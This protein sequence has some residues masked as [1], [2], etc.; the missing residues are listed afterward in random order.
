VTAKSDRAIRDLKLSALAGPAQVLVSAVAYALVYP[1]IVARS[2]L[3]VL[4]L[5]SFLASLMA[6]LGLADVGFSSLIVRKVGAN[7]TG[8]LSSVATEYVTARRF[9]VLAGAVAVVA[10]VAVLWGG[11]AELPGYASGA[12][13][14]LSI[15][16]LLVAT[17][18]QLVTQLVQAVLSGAH[19]TYATQVINGVTPPIRLAATLVGALAA[20]PIEGLAAGALLEAALRYALSRWWLARRVP[21]WRTSDVRLGPRGTW[22][23]LCEMIRQGW[24]LYAISLGFLLRE[25]VFRTVITMSLGLAATGVYEIAARIPDALRTIINAGSRALYPSFARLHALGDRERL[26][27]LIRTVLVV[28]VSGAV[29]VLGGYYV[30][31]DVLLATWLRGLSPD[32]ASAT[33]L[34]TLWSAIT[35]GNVPYWYL[36]QASGNERTAARSLWLHTGLILAVVPLSRWWPLTLDGLLVYWTATSVLTQIAI[37]WASERLFGVFR[38]TFV[39]PIVLGSIAAGVALAWV[40]QLGAPSLAPSVE[41]WPRVLVIGLGYVT[42][43]AVALAPALREATRPL[44]SRSAVIQA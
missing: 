32:V 7:T 37:Y 20:R 6:Y 31:A 39:S 38:P 25:P 22:R 43:A 44:T 11:G 8:S 5:W 14:A 41:G 35:L 24:G 30:V 3:E 15:A 34:M 26:V 4:G 27:G 23:C 1:T 21:S 16:G 13:M 2:G 9:Y 10:A 40:G 33:R 12:V 28:N 29:L 17:V 42:I 19:E 18:V 36:L